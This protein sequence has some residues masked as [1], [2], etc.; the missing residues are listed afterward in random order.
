MISVLLNTFQIPES[1]NR[2]I[3]YLA[4]VSLPFLFASFSKG[5]E[6]PCRER[7][8]SSEVISL[9]PRE[10]E[11]A[12]A[13]AKETSDAEAAVAQIPPQH[14]ASL[15]ALLNGGTPDDLMKIRGIA[16]SRA[17]AIISSRPIFE[18]EELVELRGF[19]LATLA[20]VL[21]YGEESLR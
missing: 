7:I 6:F 1:M 4:A 16:E 20:Q 11:N 13:S 10:G 12:S 2:H 8:S 19:G 18:L 15:L 14:R 9:P 5:E 17:R 21:A 3:I